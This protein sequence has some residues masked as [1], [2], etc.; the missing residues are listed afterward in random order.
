MFGKPLDLFRISLL[1]S[2]NQVHNVC[3]FGSEDVRLVYEKD[4]VFKKKVFSLGKGGK[5]K[6]KST[7]K[8]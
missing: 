2:S 1:G 6:W 8:S 4:D 7:L 5:A 3:V